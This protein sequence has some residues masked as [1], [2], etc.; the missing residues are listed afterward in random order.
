MFNFQEETFFAQKWLSYTA[1]K[2]E[3]YIQHARNGGEKRVG[4]YLLDGY[5]EETHM[6]Y[7][8]YGCF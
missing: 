3:T 4:P 2:T 1:E 8:V 6:A 5:H 7:E